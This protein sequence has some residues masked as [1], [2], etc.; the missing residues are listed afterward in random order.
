MRL[1]LGSALASLSLLCASPARAILVDDNFSNT[2]NPNDGVPWDNVGSING[3]SGV[4]LGNGWVITA[5][6]VGA[7]NITFGSSTYSP[8][9]TAVPITNGDGTE[10]DLL[11]FRL[12][13]APVLPTIRVA[14]STPAINTQVEYVGYGRTRGEPVASGALQG[15]L[16]SGSPAKSWGRNRIST[17]APE[18]VLNTQQFATSFDNNPELYEAQG[19]LGD[20]GSGVFVLRLGQWELAGIT[21]AI[22][23]RAVTNRPADSAFYGD[24]TYSGNLASYQ[25]QIFSVTGIPEPSTLA[26]AAAAWPLLM[27]RRR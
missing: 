3:A 25:S 15:Y 23:N 8:D 13:Q 10:A 16:W 24:V 6:H 19:T 7:G 1:H 11:L 18:L 17:L 14:T 20:S 12:A 27:R 5:R 4:Y 22:G 2:S 9:G 21:S 26:L